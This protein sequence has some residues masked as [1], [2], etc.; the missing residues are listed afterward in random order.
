MQTHAFMFYFFSM[1]HHWNLQVQ[2]LSYL[3]YILIIVIT[4][5]QNHVKDGALQKLFASLVSMHPV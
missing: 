1:K 3:V 5:V 4:T 2:V